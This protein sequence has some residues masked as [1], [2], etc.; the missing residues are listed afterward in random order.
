M[1]L[2]TDWVRNGK[3]QEEAA[4]RR[5]HLAGCR[6]RT[7]IS[8]MGSWKLEYWHVYPTPPR[9]IENCRPHTYDSD[10]PLLTLLHPLAYNS[11]RSSLGHSL[12]LGNFSSPA[13]TLKHAERPRPSPRISV[14][15]RK[16][17]RVLVCF[18]S[19]L[20]TFSSTLL[21]FL[22]FPVPSAP[23]RMKLQ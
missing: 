6:V 19:L 9:A 4:V 8:S 18:W 3:E 1:L 12:V 5:N 23:P 13:K 16:P 22:V 7:N 20:F 2:S 17:E 21:R 14:S 15:E 11:G 10:T